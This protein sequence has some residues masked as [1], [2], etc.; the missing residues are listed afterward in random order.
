[1][2]IKEDEIIR[3]YIYFVFFLKRRKKTRE[4]IKRHMRKRRDMQ[5]FDGL[6]FKKKKKINERLT[7][8]HGEKK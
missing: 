1:M 7:T 4:K 2:S 5:I 6:V 3:E 8:K